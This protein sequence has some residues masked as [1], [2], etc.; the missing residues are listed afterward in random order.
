MALR[1]KL[2]AN[3]SHLLE[4][5]ETIQQVFCAQ[6]TSQW[7]A[8]LSYWII[9]FKNAYRVVVVT[10]RRIM[11]C[12]SGRMTTTKVGEVLHELPRSTMIG[13]ASGLWWKCES[14]GDRLYVH[15]RFH[16]DV[17]AADAA[18]LER[19]VAGS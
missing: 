18:R 7:F 17:D 15:K 2:R 10:D 14:L 1:D 11:V 6:T 19:P 4:N 13:P 9:I 16:K 8:L 12:R 5:G 3:A